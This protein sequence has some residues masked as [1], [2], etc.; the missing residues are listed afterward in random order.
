MDNSLKVLVIINLTVC[1]SLLRWTQILF[2]FFLLLCFAPA[3]LFVETTTK[4]S[5]AS[6]F[7]Q[8]N[9]L[10]VVVVINFIMTT[11]SSSCCPTCCAATFVQALELNNNGA[12]LAKLGQYEDAIESFRH[13][14]SMVGQMMTVQHKSH[15]HQHSVCPSYYDIT[16]TV[17][18]RRKSTTPP[19]PPSSSTH[20][21]HHQGLACGQHHDDD[22]LLQNSMTTSDQAPNSTT[23]NALMA[24]QQSQQESEDTRSVGKRTSR[25]VT[26]APKTHHGADSGYGDDERLHDEGGN[27]LYDEPLFI[28]HVPYSPTRPS[29][30]PLPVRPPSSRSKCQED[31]PDDDDDAPYHD[32][33]YIAPNHHDSHHNTKHMADLSVAVMILNTAIAHHLMSMSSPNTRRLASGS[34]PRRIPQTHHDE[35]SSRFQYNDQGNGI[36]HDDPPQQSHQTAMVIT[37]ARAKRL[38]QKSIE[39]LM[40]LEQLHSDVLHQ[41][42]LQGNIYTLAKLA[43]INNLLLIMDHDDANRAS[44]LALYY[45]VATAWYIHHRT[46][47]VLLGHAAEERQEQHDTFPGSIHHHSPLSM[48]YR[49]WRNIFLENAVM[50]RLKYLGKI[51]IPHTANAA[52]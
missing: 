38:Y 12:S 18:P 27:F 22:D 15:D 35:P 25:L 13:G 10:V 37:K 48:L 29:Q 6:D 2:A 17:S 4:S 20:G 26:T 42:D 49:K 39:L 14:L 45:Q 11:S 46:I 28:E 23:T 36:E 40:G 21:Q 32:E 41:L 8:C 3:C 33:S 51:Y 30:E 9:L 52:W 7:L 1:W 5:P 44:L 19:R 16:I 47:D 24:L 50:M 43:S 31:V 34:P